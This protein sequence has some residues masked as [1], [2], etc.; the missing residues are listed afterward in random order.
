LPRKVRAAEAAVAE[1]GEP[2]LASV[3]VVVGPAECPAAAALALVVL[4]LA[5]AAGPERL[6]RVAVFGKAAEAVREVLGAV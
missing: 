6:A 4:A 5:V 3:L 1:E 2:A